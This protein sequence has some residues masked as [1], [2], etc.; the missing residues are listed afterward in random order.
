MSLAVLEALQAAPWR[1]A[2]GYA[3]LRSRYR[4]HGRSHRQPHV[5]PQCP[6]DRPAPLDPA[7]REH[8]H[9]GRRTE[10]LLF[11]SPCVPDPAGAT[12]ATPLRDD[13]PAAS[14][15]SPTPL[16]CCHGGSAA[17]RRAEL[18]DYRGSTRYCSTTTA[19]VALMVCVGVCM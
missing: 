7:L 10:R 3:R 14:S 11:I 15:R 6:G 18:V 1:P 16:R 9:R 12:A 5:F 19:T 2:E 8:K 17:V 13:R 4:V